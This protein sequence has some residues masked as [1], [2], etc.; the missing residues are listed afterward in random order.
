MQLSKLKFIY[1]TLI[2]FSSLTQGD[3]LLSHQQVTRTWDRSEVQISL[4]GGQLILPQSTENGAGLSFSFQYALSSQFALSSRLSQL[5]NVGD[6]FS[7][8]YSGLGA[9]IFYNLSDTY[10]R[11][12]WALPNADGSGHLAKIKFN[13]GSSWE[14]GGGFEQLLLS[15]NQVAYSAPG[16]SLNLRRRFLFLRNFYQ[17]GF[18]YGQYQNN[19]QS[20]NSLIFFFTIPLTM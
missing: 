13:R 18:K 12:E 3:S 1:F 5:Y 9:E 7:L 2:F 6:N 4:E 14:I 10:L 20:I 17:V 19:R 15:G 11:G 16:I 8:L